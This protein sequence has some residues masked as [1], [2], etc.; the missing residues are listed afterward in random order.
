MTLVPEHTTLDK[1]IFFQIRSRSTLDFLVLVFIKY[2]SS[3]AATGITMNISIEKCLIYWL[4]IWWND[5]LKELSLG[6][7][8]QLLFTIHIY[9]GCPRYLSHVETHSWKRSSS[10]SLILSFTIICRDMLEVFEDQWSI[11]I[12]RGNNHCKASSPLK[13]RTKWFHR[14]SNCQGPNEWHWL[15]V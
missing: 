7:H 1:Y 6:Y 8:Y 15:Y 2:G 9:L 5:Y 13:K 3:V 14:V 10:Q 11:A 4:E 12:W